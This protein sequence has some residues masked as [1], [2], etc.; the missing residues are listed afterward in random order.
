[1]STTE[2]PETGELEST[3]EA[4]ADVLAS[5]R[6]AIGGLRDTA[7]VARV[8]GDPIEANEKTIVP[9]ARVAYGFGAGYGS[10]TDE[11]D[12]EAGGEG[13]GGGGGASVTPVGILE[14]TDD[15]TRYVRFS[16]WRRTAVAVGTGIGL[17]VLLGRR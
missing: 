5:V 11:E 14:I 15:D 8:F 1:M 13:A 3:F 17:G 6:D 10:G 16:D 4:E 2:E 7:S 12:E 9:V